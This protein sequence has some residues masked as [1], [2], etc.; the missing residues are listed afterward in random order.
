MID[1]KRMDELRDEIGQEGFDEIVDVFLEE[2]GEVVARLA[3]TGQPT[4]ED[5]HFLKGSA[6]NL[7]FVE[8]AAMCQD[9]ERTLASDGRVD[10]GRL[11][12]AFAAARGDLI[13]NRSARAA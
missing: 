3:A 7:G 1:W 11:V 5:L 13:Q 2:A 10:T 12:T 4:G 9:A 6:L 8:V